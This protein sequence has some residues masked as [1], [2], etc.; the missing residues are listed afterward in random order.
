MNADVGEVDD[1]INAT[2]EYF[3]WFSIIDVK[4]VVGV[5][6]GVGSIVVE[7]DFED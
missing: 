7:V 2:V 5:F 1:G 4:G 3:G 6:N